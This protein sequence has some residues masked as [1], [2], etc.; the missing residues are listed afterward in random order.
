MYRFYDIRKVVAGFD[1][2]KA[3]YSSASFSPRF[4]LCL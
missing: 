2:G 4:A 1:A 3:A